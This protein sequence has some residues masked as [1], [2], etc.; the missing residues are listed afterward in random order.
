MASNLS[1]R[2]ETAMWKGLMVGH[3]TK[4]SEMV[5][6]NAMI[7]ARIS[8]ATLADQAGGSPSADLVDVS[9]TNIIN[10]KGKASRVPMLE[11]TNLD[12]EGGEFKKGSEISGAFYDNGNEVVGEFSK[13]MIMGVFGALEYEMD[14]TMM[15][16]N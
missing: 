2:G 6:G 16:G 15:A 4:E 1:G 5:K 8:A 7:T 10:D 14:D 11:W 12:L 13:S 3:D 9:L